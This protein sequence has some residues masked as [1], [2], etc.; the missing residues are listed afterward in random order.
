L[1]NTHLF[2]GSANTYDSL[3]EAYWLLGNIEAAVNG[4]EKVL[5]MQPDN[6]YA[7]KQLA[8]LKSITNE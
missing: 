7:E 2:P 5:T 8:K 4:Y 3:A 1:L 6:D